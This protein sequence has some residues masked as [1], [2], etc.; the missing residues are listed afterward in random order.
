MLHEDGGNTTTLAKPQTTQLSL[1]D[2]N[3][4]KNCLILRELNEL[5]K[6]AILDLERWLSH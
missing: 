5:I 6:G 3:Y 1:S 4:L 2:T